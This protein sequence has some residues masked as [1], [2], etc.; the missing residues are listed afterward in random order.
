[1]FAPEDLIVL[2]E[3]M[4]P[5]SV[6]IQ[7][8]NVPDFG[9]FEELPRS[10]PILS[11]HLTDHLGENEEDAHSPDTM[12]IEDAEEESEQP[13]YIIIEVMEGYTCTVCVAGMNEIEIE[14]EIQKAREEI[15]D[16]I[17]DGGDNYYD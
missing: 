13:D 10:A 11:K 1:M 5:F 7:I 15:I 6:S 3:E 16:L 17:L 8:P 9:D 14:E 12:S 4:Q 2:N